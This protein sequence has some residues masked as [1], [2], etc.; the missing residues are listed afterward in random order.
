MQ[1][2]RKPNCLSHSRSGWQM[3]AI[4]APEPVPRVWA[5]RLGPRLSAS[6]DI[7]KEYVDTLAAARISTLAKKQASDM[8]RFWKKYVD[9]DVEL[10]LLLCHQF[11]RN[12]VDAILWVT[13]DYLEYFKIE[14]SNTPSLG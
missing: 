14:I 4:T 9:H 6:K 5:D 8:E 10:L 7:Q 13:N 12:T 1:L 2:G 3:G 11:E